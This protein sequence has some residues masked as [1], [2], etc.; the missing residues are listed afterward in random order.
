MPRKPERSR[1]SSKRTRRRDALSLLKQDHQ[2]ILG[3]FDRFAHEAGRGETASRLLE[4]ACGAFEAHGQIE[5]EIFYPA[6]RLA[7]E[8]R[9]WLEEGEVEHRTMAILVEELRTVRPGAPRPVATARVLVEMLGHHLAK[10]E[11]RLFAQVRRAPIDLVGLGEML[12]A[13]RTDILEQRGVVVP[14]SSPESGERRR[15]YSGFAPF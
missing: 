1:A 12:R 13:R 15:G 14:G 6:V 5:D 7:I 3:L 11:R 10:E 9:E 4:E 8:C 2:R